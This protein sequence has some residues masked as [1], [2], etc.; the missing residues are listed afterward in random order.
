MSELRSWGV[1]FYSDVEATDEIESIDLG[2]VWEGESAEVTVYMR[3]D[4]PHYARDISFN[5]AVPEV[6]V[7]GPDTMLPG[8]VSPLRLRWGSKAGVEL[9]L[10]SDV[11]VRAVLVL[12]AP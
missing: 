8:A 11:E 1:S 2:E 5:V 7:E 3:N 4:E 9:S 12:R 6:T 10:R